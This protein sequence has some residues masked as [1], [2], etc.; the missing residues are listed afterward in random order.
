MNESERF[1]PTEFEVA[2]HTI[3]M[4]LAAYKVQSGVLPDYP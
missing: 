1:F 3:E 2:D 4:I